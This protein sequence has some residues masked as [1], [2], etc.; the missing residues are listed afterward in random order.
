MNKST[1]LFKAS[2]LA[3]AAVISVCTINANAQANYYTS[4]QYQAEEQAFRAR[5]NEGSRLYE[6]FGPNSG[7][8]VN[9]QIREKGITGTGNPYMFN[10]NPYYNNPYGSSFYWGY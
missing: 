10:V 7:A 9:W 8:Y 1:Q 6:T 5:Q 2:F 3:A 4:P